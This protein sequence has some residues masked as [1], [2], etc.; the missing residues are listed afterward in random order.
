MK[1]NKKKVFLPVIIMLIIEVIIAFFFLKDNSIHIT[2]EHYKWSIF[3]L[4]FNANTM[5]NVWLVSLFLIITGYIAGKRVKLKPDSRI[6][7]VYE[8]IIEAFDDL[9]K[10]TLGSRSRK[11]FPLIM[12]L[13]LFLW[14]SNMMGI[15]P[16]IWHVINI[17][18]KPYLDWL[19]FAEPTRDINVPFGLM[20]LVI[21]VVHASMIK[22]LGFKNYLKSYG[23]P[24]VFLAPLNVIGEM[25]KGISLAFRIFGNILGGAIIIIVVSSLIRHIA[26]PPLLNGF[27]G[28]FV[29][30]IQAFV[31]AMLSLTYTAVAIGDVIEEEKKQ[32]KE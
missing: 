25:A 27:F 2:T 13:F 22:E 19:E 8:M 15:L 3:G 32:K 4:K 9:T 7:A 21:F 31:F 17:N 26:L 28:I 16:S 18:G 1:I 23:D 12:T 6:V 29:G 11:Y 20:L 30:T 10:Q 5:I 24:I 14:L